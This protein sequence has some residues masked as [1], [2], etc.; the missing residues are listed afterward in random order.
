MR[1][2]SRS[3]WYLT[4]NDTVRCKDGSIYTITGA[5]VG[6]G[7]SSVLYPASRSGSMRTYVLKECFPSTDNAYIRRNG[8]VCPA[9]DTD[10]EAA[11][12]LEHMRGFFATE[13]HLGQ[14]LASKSRRSIGAWELLECDS[15][16]CGGET[17]PASDAVFTVFDRLDEQGCFL[18]DI[19]AECRLDAD[20]AHPFRTGGLPHIHTAAQIMCELLKALNA[21]H[22]A[23]YIHGDIQDGNL[24]FSDARLNRGDLGFGC[25]IDF[26]CA[27]ELEADGFTPAIRSR[28]IC[29]TQGFVP[30]ECILKN[31]GHL[32]LGKS[33]DIYSCGRL[34]LFLLTGKTFCRNGRDEIH[35]NPALKQLLPS[36][37]RKI[38]CSRRA[39]E[40]VNSIL[41]RALRND[42]EERYQDAADMLADLEY[43]E[44]LSREPRYLLPANLA[45]TDY[46]VPHSRDAELAS[47]SRILAY[48][49]PVW[50]RGLGGMGKT[51]LAVA[52][53]RQEQHRCGCP[54]FLIQ[55][56]GSLRET[57]ADLNFTG[58][59]FHP[60]RKSMTP[61]EITEQKYTE[62]I[63]IL[64]EYSSDTILVIDNL[65][66][67]KK[68]FS[69]IRAEPEYRDLIGLSCRIVITTRYNTP[70]TPGIEI[71][72]LTE[73]HLLEM[74]RY[75]CGNS[76]SEADL[77]SLIRAVGHHTLMVGLVAKTIRKRTGI[78]PP[79]LLDALSGQNLSSEE[80]PSLAS[81]K[82]REY[83][84]A[85]I[86]GHLR[87]LFNMNEL[88]DEECILMSHASL[89]PD[90][91]LEYRIFENCV[92]P[93]LR[94]LIP[95]MIDFGW[96]ISTTEDTVKVH[97]L[98][99]DVCCEELKPDLD[100]CA[101]FLTGIAHSYDANEEYDVQKFTQLA[102]LFRT[103]HSIL[104]DPIAVCLFHTNY[105]YFVMG[106]WEQQLPLAQE[107]L[108]IRRENLPELNPY[109]AAAYNNLAVAYMNIGKYDQALPNALKAVEI[110]EM[111]PPEEQGDLTIFYEMLSLICGKIGERDLEFEYILK[112]AEIKT[113]ELDPD[114]L[115]LADCYTNLANAY[116]NCRGDCERARDYMMRAYQIRS[117]V[118]P[119]NHPLLATSLMNLSLTAIAFEEYTEALEY[120]EQARELFLG[121]GNENHPNLFMLY[122]NEGIAYAALDEHDK[123]LTALQAAEEIAARIFPA[124]SAELPMLYNN[125]ASTYCALEQPD[126]AHPYLEKS[127][128]ITESVLT[129]DHFQR[130]RLCLFM[131]LYYAMKEASEE[132]LPWFIE[133]EKII[134]KNELI[135]A[136]ESSYLK[137]MLAITYHD[138]GRYAEA[139]PYIKE[140]AESDPPNLMTELGFCYELG[141]G[142]RRNPAL[143]FKWYRKAVEYNEDEDNTMYLGWA[144]LDGI[145]CKPDYEK[146]L[147]YLNRAAELGSEDEQLPELIEK[148]QQKLEQSLNPKKSFFGRFFGKQ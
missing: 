85:S 84:E 147:Y 11:G 121:G 55:Y 144:Y 78:T 43:L 119:D 26:G 42:P 102:E 6:I 72:P 109:V 146:A 95:K 73:P 86:Y 79:K 49:S 130:G 127:L 93:Q 5:P 59:E 31:D 19:L 117:Q 2:D 88:T 74:M 89:L 9:S 96:I 48:E 134:G 98:I 25:L 111:L 140:C 4:A 68:K 40:T 76:V 141:H 62:K 94:P 53:A 128:A 67:P 32:R 122:N 57:V 92:D 63:E 10:R 35:R 8:V 120:L 77:L 52:F 41:A 37:C 132:A 99:R 136:G 45:T 65:Y 34:L 71:Q 60:A 13:K 142:V 118:L 106:D 112:S 83:R 44:Q 21:I 20:P 105:L 30:P 38:S 51:E 36:D 114:D 126:L 33:T 56:H 100:S 91:G 70:D 1:E 104:D 139:F 81:D 138:L 107:I 123:A 64:R 47:L 80:F 12:Y 133:A 137:S 145:G 66:D 18:S 61:Q 3:A 116:L 54:A 50:I 103:A 29:S 46:F 90:C 108:E 58:Y 115:A 69:E 101:D 148:A 97:S 87:T 27:R 16:T 7:G 23:G 75:I 15:I 14:I 82:D 131:G 39:M 24:F 135:M 110:G 125:I 129:P 113:A 143:A 22:E 28:V 124:D 17:W